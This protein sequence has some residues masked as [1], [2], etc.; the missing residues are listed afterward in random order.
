MFSV[1]WSGAVGIHWLEDKGGQNGFVHLRRTL[2]FA[3]ATSPPKTEYI[4]ASGS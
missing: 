1:I 2:V 3:T 4:A